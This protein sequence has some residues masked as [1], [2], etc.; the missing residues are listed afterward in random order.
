M[1]KCMIYG[2]CQAMAMK[3]FLSKYPAFSKEYVII[4]IKPVHLLDKDDLPFL[5]SAT[6]SLDLFIHQPVSDN[7]KGM[8]QL[9]TKALINRLPG[10]CQVVSFPVAYFTGYHPEITCLR[11][12]NGPVK[13]DPFPYHDINFLRLYHQ[14]KTIQEILDIINDN[15][16]YTESYIQTNLD[17]TL[18]TLRSRENSL[19]VKLSDFIER[20]FRNVKLFH[21][22][23]HPSKE[24]LE[25]L[26]ESILKDVG[27]H[28]EIKLSSLL[29]NID[30]LAQ[31][32]FPIHQSLHNKAG[33]N[34]WSDPNYQIANRKYS[35][36]EAIKLYYDFY[37]KNHNKIDDFLT[38]TV[39][40]T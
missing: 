21:S 39:L 23:N 28:V 8:P 36:E 11:D 35:Q 14:G 19:T 32:S 30:V 20:E 40:R 4:D 34:F 22:F 27:I 31:T 17:K 15:D 3:L 1:K 24:I 37:R 13:N 9:S 25:F 16:L 18:A 5:E 12:E 7:Y 33:L 10:S 2:N 29:K 26:F 6:L 38:H